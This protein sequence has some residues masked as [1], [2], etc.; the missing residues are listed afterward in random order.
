MMNENKSI[1]AHCGQPIEGEAIECRGRTYCETCADELLF[2]C[3]EC[4]EWEMQE[5]AVEV[6]DLRGW[7]RRERFVCSDCFDAE[8]FE[9]EECGTRFLGT[10][11]TSR[12]GDVICPD[13]AE[14]VYYF[15]DEC[16]SYVRSE[17]YDG[18]EE[19][20]TFCLEDSRR[21]N[22]SRYHG[23][24]SSFPRFFADGEK[25][26]GDFIGIGCEIEID[27]EHY[28]SC[29]ERDCLQALNETLGDRVVYEHDGSLDNGFEIVTRPHTIRAFLDEFPLEKVLNICRDN[30]YSAH[31]IGTCGFHMHISRRFFGKDSQ[32]QERSI[33][34]V[35]AFFD[36]F[37]LDLVK[38]SRR[39]M[40]RASRWA[41]RCGATTPDEARDKAKGS[42]TRYEAV[43]T[44][45]SATIEFRL[46]R[47]TLNAETLRATLDILLTICRNAKKAT[48]NEAFRDPVKMLGGLNA[49]SVDYIASRNAFSQYISEI[50]DCA[51]EGK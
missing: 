39:D 33:G 10:P 38:V 30:G 19:T 4:D 43:N 34:K 37:Y 48:W 5:N 20:C 14:S 24:N 9:C 17:H 25:H 26:V 40:S 36:A 47:G 23:A 16:D 18:D 42:N 44:T 49:K 41:S 46:M 31:D 35:V 1:C 45:N 21:V 50:R 7:R 22:I 51:K 28:S 6:V 3:E 2:I 11:R 8:G 15:C 12:E 29:A 13:C 27:R 32:T